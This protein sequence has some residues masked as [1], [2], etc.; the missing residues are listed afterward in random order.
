MI[1]VPVDNS[2]GLAWLSRAQD[3]RLIA[4]IWKEREK[5]TG[6]KTGGRRGMEEKMDPL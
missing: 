3:T 2:P 4:A 6:N 1:V 5:K